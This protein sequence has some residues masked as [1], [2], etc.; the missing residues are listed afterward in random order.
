M[1][2]FEQSHYGSLQND[3]IG[4][5]TQ[6]FA[7]PRVRQFEPYRAIVILLDIKCSTVYDVRR[8]HAWLQTQAHSCAD[9][10]RAARA[11]PTRTVPLRPLRHLGEVWV[12]VC[13]RPRGG[14]VC[15]SRSAPARWR[16]PPG[17]L[18]HGPLGADGRAR[19]DRGLRRPIDPR[20]GDLVCTRVASTP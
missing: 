13:V 1:F 3:A 6:F 12:R 10:D 4:K 5:M 8:F 17:W 18:C 7:A 9:P 15:A 14:P 16:C 11:T 2:A 20:S 19:G